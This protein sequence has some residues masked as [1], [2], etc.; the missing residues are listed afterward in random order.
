[1]LKQYLARRPIFR[2]IVTLHVVCTVALPELLHISC[3]SYNVITFHT[4]QIQSVEIVF[5]IQKENSGSV[6]SD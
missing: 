3:T 5:K 4:K 1:M 2:N 6:L